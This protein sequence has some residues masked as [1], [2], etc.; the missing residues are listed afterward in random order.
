[1]GPRRGGV[2]AASW[3]AKAW[4]RAVEESAYGERDLRDGRALARGGAVGGI[5]VSPGRLLAGVLQ[6]DDVWT[7]T[8]DVPVLAE[9]SVAAFGELVAA[10]SGRIARLL[11]GDLPLE[12]AE[13]AEEAGVEL[14]PYGGELVAECTCG[15]WT[16]PCRHALAV[17]LQTGWLVD[18]DPLTLVL[19]RGLPR[20]EL[21]AAL[22]ARTVAQPETEPADP[23]EEAAYDAAVRARRLLD[24]LE[25]GD[26]GTDLSHLL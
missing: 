17:L 20:E 22:H 18:G 10:E 13:H 7:V 4:L 8:V 21:L 14:L 26:D 24:L 25:S 11:A 9:E 5:T 15:A 2:R 6:D 1:M 23:D 12:L 3:W 19:L 16:Q